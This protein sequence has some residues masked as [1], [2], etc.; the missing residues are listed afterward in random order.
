MRRLMRSSFRE[1]I[2]D[3]AGGVRVCVLTF[4][5]RKFFPPASESSGEV[6]SESKEEKQ[7]REETSVPDLPDVP[8]K[9]PSE[10]G[11]P[12]TKKAKL[13]ANDDKAEK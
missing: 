11:Q 13:K 4:V 1:C 5:D 12:D 2:G 3:G 8:T 7:E 6:E 10:A 9:E